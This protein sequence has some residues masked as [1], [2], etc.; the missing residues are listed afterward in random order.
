MFV[1]PPYRA[2][3]VTLPDCVP[4]NVT[5]HVPFTNVHEAVLNE[6]NPVPLWVHVTVPV[7]EYPETFAV[8]VAVVVFSDDDTAKTAGVQ[9]MLIVD[10]LGVTFRGAGLV[11]IEGRLLESPV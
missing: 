8:Q 6:T 9:R 1:S 3:T 5:S 2:E 7:G 4:V 10:G 11:P